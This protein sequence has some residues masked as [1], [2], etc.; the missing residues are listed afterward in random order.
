M[1]S[2]GETRTCSTP[3]TRVV[4]ISTRCSVGGNTCPTWGGMMAS[5][6]VDE[7]Q[8]CH[9]SL[10]G[11]GLTLCARCA[12]VCLSNGHRRA[13]AGSAGGFGSS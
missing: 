4:L 1:T 13:M 8:V 2:G 5:V 3:P 6:V 7:Q 12:R 11:R 9:G 10:S